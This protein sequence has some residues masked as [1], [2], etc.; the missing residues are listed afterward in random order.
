MQMPAINAGE[1]ASSNGSGVASVQDKKLDLSTAFSQNF[2]ISI[3]INFV[4]KVLL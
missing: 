1:I 2:T 4:L 3:L